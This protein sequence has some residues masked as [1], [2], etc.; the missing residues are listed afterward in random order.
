M[1]KDENTTQEKKTRNLNRYPF[2][3]INDRCLLRYGLFN[4]FFIYL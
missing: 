4:D 2:W 1:E 3:H